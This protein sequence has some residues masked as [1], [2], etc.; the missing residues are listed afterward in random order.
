MKILLISANTV[1]VP[2][3]VYPLGLDYVAG[4][5][6][7]RH[8]V[9]VAD[10][11]LYNKTAPIIDIIRDF[12]PD[13][14]GLSLRNIDNT[15]VHDAR[16]FIPKYRELIASIRSVSV[17]PV[18]LGGSG[19]TIFPRL[20]MTELKADYGIIGEGERLP[21][22][23]DA[24]EKGADASGIPGVIT[25]TG[26]EK[27]PPPFDD[28]FR[29]SFIG[30][31]IAQFYTAR[32]GILN[33][34][35]KRGC[36]YNCIYC[37]YPHIE[38]SAL[39]PIPA[40]EVAETAVT[41]EAMGGKYFFI[42][43]SA[44]NCDYEH[45][46]AVARS[47]KSRGVTIPWGA[48]LAPTKPPADYYRLLSDAGMTHAEFGTESLSDAM[49]ASYRKPFNVR[50]AIASH[51]A[52]VDAGLYVAHYLLLGGPGETRETIEETLRN[53]EGLDR[54]VLFFFCGIRIYPHTRIYDIA[55]SE[56]QISEGDNLLEPVFYQSR[57]ISSDEILRV[58]GERARG[59]E[60]WFVG[61]TS[62]HTTRL[63]A[64]MHRQGH[65]G[66]LWEHMIR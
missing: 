5:L 46:A 56:G 43:D 14:I 30:G 32:G 19:F 51:R 58:V 49:L 61:S 11:N 42:T 47:F 36:S 65:T 28:T 16:G 41:L 13:A 3:Y 15:D 63:V 7:G 40:E 64:R 29:R 38:G 33:L 50:D 2:Y 62:E 8:T 59:R 22:L 12:G 18:I 44:F 53:A 25:G 37:T 20:L 39:R 34:Q 52:A 60:N 57:G 4:A 1:R 24:I 45:S 9:R 35:T 17:A 21:L 23:L 54:T 10:I 6:E 26:E 31:D 48:F 27:I 55:L 66:P